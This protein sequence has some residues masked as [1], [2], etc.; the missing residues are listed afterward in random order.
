MS[1]KNLLPRYKIGIIFAGI[2]LFISILLL[3]LHLISVPQMGDMGTGWYWFIIILGIPL[4]LLF[5]YE[6][7]YF[8]VNKLIYGVKHPSTRSEAF[9]LIIFILLNTILYFIAGYLIGLLIEKIR[10]RKVATPSKL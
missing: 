7:L 6:K 2:Y 3:I 1:Y 4:Y 5:G 9:P 10:K 8:A